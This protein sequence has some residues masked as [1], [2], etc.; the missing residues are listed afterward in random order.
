M[1]LRLDAEISTYERK[2][3]FQKTQIFLD[4]KRILDEEKQERLLDKIVGCAHER[5]F[6]L[7]LKAEFAG[8]AT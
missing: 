6:L 1:L 7:Q 4:V 8:I 5:W 3:G 2:Y